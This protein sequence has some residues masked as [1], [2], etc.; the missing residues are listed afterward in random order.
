MYEVANLK[1]KELQKI[2]QVSA[3][4]LS[5]KFKTIEDEN[6]I[7]RK[8]SRITGISPELVENYLTEAGYDHF[9]KR[10]CYFDS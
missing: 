5:R 6:L 1:L 2:A 3:P 7:S 4:L 10:F 9:Y 8:N